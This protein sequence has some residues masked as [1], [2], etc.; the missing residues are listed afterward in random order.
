MSKNVDRSMWEGSVL[1]DDLECGCRKG[2]PHHREGYRTSPI[3][4]SAQQFPVGSSKFF[5]T[6]FRRPFEKLIV[7]ENDCEV[8]RCDPARENS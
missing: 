5:E 2:R 7:Y 1:P 6:D 4:C 3:I 8:C